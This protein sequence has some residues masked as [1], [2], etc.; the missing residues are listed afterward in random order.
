MNKIS[1]GNMVKKM[2][3]VMLFL[4][5]ILPAFGEVPYQKVASYGLDVYFRE[6]G[7]GTPVLVLGG[8]PGDASD[9]YLSLCEG[10]AKNHRSWIKQSEEVFSA[11]KEFLAEDN[12]PKLSGPCLGQKPPGTTPEVFAPGVVSRDGI[13][14]KLTMTANGSEILY[15]ERDPATNAAS[16][17]IR[18]R[19]GDSWGEP[20]VLPYSREYMEIEPSL[21][22]GGKK[23]LFVSNRPASGEGEP[24][25]MPDIWMAEKTGDQ[26]GNPVRLAPP[27]L[28]DD[29]ADLEA[30][31]A[32]LPDGGI[33]FMRQNGKTRR[34]YQAASRGGG[35]AEPVAVPLKEDLLAGQFSGPCFSPDGRTLLMHSR[36]EGGFGNWDLYVAFKD[37]SGV[38]SE[39]KNLGPA[40]NT[41]KPES[42][43]TF[44]SDGRSIFFTRDTDVFWVSTKFIDDMRR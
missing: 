13:Q 32:F 33:Y 2:S 27:I 20:V 36:K 4:S 22:P 15:T 43:P 31:P 38:W 21:S 14:M 30:H 3:C 37:E 26:W 28:T 23:I 40:V 12:F 16:F 9:R 18:S 42:C 35:F 29:P 6:F 7:E 34:L 44:S 25:K 11:I 41:E 39:F 24:Q 5:I 17:I 1:A 10:L 19:A 8:D